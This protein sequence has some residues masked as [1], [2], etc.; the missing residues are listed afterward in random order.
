[1]FSVLNFRRENVALYFVANIIEEKRN[2]ELDAIWRKYNFEFLMEYFEQAIGNYYWT[3][4]NAQHA[5][6]LP[7]V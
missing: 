2:F 7:P 6:S 4:R 1:M 3:M 5:V